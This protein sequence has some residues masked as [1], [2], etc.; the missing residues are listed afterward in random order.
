MSR[1]KRIILIIFV[2]IVIIAVG[3][4]VM[5]NNISGKLDT[6]KDYDFSALDLTRVEDGIYTG[7]EDAGIIKATVE[8]TIKDHVITEVKILSHDSGQGKPAEVIV[9]DIVANNNLEVDAISGATYSSQVI[10]VA[11]YNALTKR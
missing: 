10:K 4:G 8:V 1:G 3:I 6:Y 5:I 9:E 11:V 7:S 2:A